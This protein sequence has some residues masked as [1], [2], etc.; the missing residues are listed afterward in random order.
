M[1]TRR[2]I[3]FTSLQIL[4]IA[5]LGTIASLPAALILRYKMDAAS[6][7]QA[8]SSGVSPAAPA[9][10]QGTGQ[11]YQQGP[12]PG[13]SYGMIRLPVGGI[14]QSVALT[15]LTGD[16]VATTSDPTITAPS[17]VNA[18]V[19][20]FT[21]MAWIKPTTVSGA[22]RVFSSLSG[23]N[24]AWGFGINGQKMRFTDYGNY[25]SDST[26]APIL[27]N[28]WQHLAVVKSS[29]AGVQFYVNGSLSFT[30]SAHPGNLT[31]AP[32][33]TTAWHLLSGPSSE[34]FLGG[35]AEIRL[36]D[37]ALNPAEI[38]I[39]AGHSP[40]P[41]G[42]LGTD[43]NP[44]TNPFLNF[45]HGLK[46]DATSSPLTPVTNYQALTVNRPA[47]RMGNAT[48][49]LWVG[50]SASSGVGNVPFPSAGGTLTDWP[51]N[52]IFHAWSGGRTGF[53]TS[54]LTVPASGF[55]D[56][57]ATW[58]AL[59][60]AGAKA[61]V[62]VVRN[63]TVLFNAALDGFLASN[64]ST[65]PPAGFARAAAFAQRGVTL[66]AGDTIDFITSPDPA[67]PAGN[68]AVDFQVV[69]VAAP[70]IATNS[71]V[72]SEFLASNQ[73]ALADE[74]GQFG[75]WIEIYNGTGAAIDL[76]GWGLTDNAA[77]PRKWTFPPRML[78]HGEYLVVFADNQDGI[79]NSFYAPTSQLHT[80]FQLSADG[81]YL[82]LVDPTGATVDQFTPTF[83]SQLPD[84][85]YG[86]AGT[87]GPAIGYLTPTPGKVNGQP[88][89]SI[90]SNVT[91][92]VAPGRFTAGSPISVQL[93]ATATSGQVIRYTLDNSE[94]TLTS[95][96]TY[97]G[98]PL[99]ISTTTVVRARAFVNGLKGILA[100]ANYL[101]VA[102][103]AQ[104]DPA[105]SYTLPIMVID[106]LGGG[107][108]TGT[109]KKAMI[110]VF[111]PDATGKASL[112]N[113]PTVL[114][115]GAS[116]VRGQSSSG[117]KKQGFSLE[118][119]DETDGDRR[120]PLLGLPSNGDWAL[121]APYDFDRVYF[122][123]RLAYGLAARLGRYAPRTRFVELYVNP[124]GGALSSAHYYGI[125]VLAETVEV[126]P[127]RVDV[128]PL[129]PTDNLGDAVTGGYIVSINKSD[130]A[131][132]VLG[133]NLPYMRNMQQNNL[134]IVTT[135]GMTTF[136]ESPKP[137]VVTNQQ[138]AYIDNYLKLTE[139]AIYGTGFKNPAT[140]L[141]YTEYL[142]RD[143]F[144]DYHIAQTLPQ[145]IDALRLSTY[146]YKD[147][148][149]KLKA[150][151]IWDADRSL[152]SRDSR[153]NNPAIWDT[154]TNLD[155]TEYFH[156]GWYH[157]LFQDPDF[158]QLWVDRY[159]ELRATGGALNYAGSILP[160][161]DQFAAEV[162]PAGTTA[163]AMTRDYA[164]WAVGAAGS[165]SDLSSGRLPYAT[166]V[167]NV[168]TW[169]QSRLAFMDG[170]ILATP[171]V[172]A[173]A[174]GSGGQTVTFTVAG[175][176]AGTQILV[177]TDGTDP[178][179]AG[180]AAA[181]SA[182]VLSSGGSLTVSAT[183]RLRFR[184]RNLTLVAFNSDSTTTKMS[185]WSGLGDS[186]ITIGAALA[187]PGDVTISALHYHPANPTQAERDAGFLTDTPF[188]FIELINITNH[189]I[190][191][192]GSRFSE[193][194]T[195]T[196]PA[197]PLAQLA[198]GERVL[199]V[200]NLAAF[201]KRYTAAA[202]ARVI[203]EYGATDSL[204]NGGETLTLLASNGTTV[205]LS[206]AYDDT[207]DWPA[208]PDGSGP[209]LVLRAPETNPSLN[210][211]ANWRASVA[212][213]GTPGESDR[214][215]FT[216]WKTAHAIA[217]N[218]DDGDQDG[219][220]A[221]LEYA[222]GSSP[223]ASSLT[224]LPKLIRLGNGTL[225][226]QFQRG[227]TADDAQW[228]LLGSTDLHTWQNLTPTI[229]NRTVAGAVESFTLA[230]PTT[231]NAPQ[232]FKIRF[233]IP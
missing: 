181:A 228:Q 179:V 66:A 159:I 220:S 222:L 5:L 72:I 4:L 197:T 32:N 127:D 85:A 178:R 76:T 35:V 117:Y 64:L 223:E 176:G 167:A 82:A 84:L 126:D 44:S 201:S 132:T 83:P 17:R 226:F 174:N 90:P 51:G 195:F 214:Q 133:A 19:N 78:A 207:P 166:E 58:K 190:T 52:Q 230:L 173:V 145:N 113:V 188:E 105:T 7:T 199:L 217:S 171:T 125:Y 216:A 50:R 120:I 219:L 10:A 185:K 69:P 128:T 160:L 139:D 198:P 63:G 49:D 61:Q 81:E 62:Y 115:C 67:T 48:D 95:G 189:P 224:E 96:S 205:L 29:T 221:A 135:G 227:L 215:T 138:R 22:H 164:R 182:T 175:A 191:L 162:S 11:S 104:P 31:I 68:L 99:T 92:S 136:L 107:T 143:T 168:K 204:D 37:T 20:N 36:Y 86:R 12:V 28:V 233:T 26:N 134:N 203:G 106:T 57:T 122:N 45:T 93:L 18:L 231:P 152:G 53:L 79:K 144:I 110:A 108:L 208:G 112:A 232:F 131:E 186:V 124:S 102:G 24:G 130:E 46:A 13:G 59:T 161:I 6:G 141:A 118:F 47:D 155:K 8:E 163:N 1:I 148:L 75:D 194:V 183:T 123:N 88:S 25:D 41:T 153:N 213:G 87:V 74:D 149:G 80:N 27:P 137:A 71:L 151:P 116:H 192:A 156:Y 193:G 39:A 140:G 225:A 150:G 196:F 103:A 94:P 56:L 42:I 229:L 38:L 55:Y 91:F 109:E 40:T 119:R 209:A 180:G 23:S 177:T 114:N 170:Q 54:R 142:G 77:Q 147:R 97:S 154:N 33:S 70:P 21:V 218:T 206:L 187:T 211:G 165:G 65:A 15:G 101:F 100:E 121:Y 169:L 30:D 3:P 73:S 98:N 184:H 158:M 9:I 43:F 60:Q 157:R 16:W 89:S 200:N 34:Y 129:S 210:S 202:A 111:E 2:R 14:S 172:S 212:S 146:F